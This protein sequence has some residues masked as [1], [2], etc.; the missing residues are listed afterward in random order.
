MV[1][2]NTTNN[3][4]AGHPSTS[5][6]S[7]GVTSAWLLFWALLVVGGFFYIPNFVT[8]GAEGIRKR[9]EAHNATI[10]R[11]KEE[12][13][14]V[15]NQRDQSR[16]LRARASAER[17]Q[18]ELESA[19]GGPARLAFA[20]PNL[21]ILEAMEQTLQA[22][23]PPN[24]RAEVRVDRFTEFT[25]TISTFETLST[26]QMIMIARAF[27]PLAR[28]YLEALRFSAKGEVV[29]ELDRQ[30]IELVENWATVP[31]ARLAMLLAREIPGAVAA[32]PKAVEKFL[33]EQRMMAALADDGI[34]AKAAA[35]DRE[36]REAAQAAYNDLKAALDLSHKGVTTFEVKTLS[37]VDAREKILRD[38]SDHVARAKAFWLAPAKV[39]EAAMDAHGLT[40]DAREA[41][42][43]ALANSFHHDQ[44]KTKALFTA[45]DGLLETG[46]Y[47]LRT[48]SENS[49][50]WRYVPQDEGLSFRDAAV[51]AQVS[52]IREQLRGDLRALDE[53]LRAW[54]ESTAQ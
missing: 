14:D 19:L 42:S 32:D 1:E 44:R 2:E 20:I 12:M 52:R 45:L 13:G 23:A 39:W 40:G 46:R 27:M 10:A 43:K 16:Y 49:D 36:F 33:D 48:L 41:I 50:K 30:D 6:A 5:R 54:Q 3:P 8:G 47:L 37:D 51:G 53:A 29:A 35:V 28:D 25:A 24:S 18:R 17:R 7:A 26:N 38:A 9:S 15:I 22:C 31:D 21:S 11:L 4:S 34:R